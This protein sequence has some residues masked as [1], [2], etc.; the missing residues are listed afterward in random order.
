MYLRVLIDLA[1]AGT[2]TVSSTALAETSGVNA[3]KVRKDMSHLRI[4]G[5]RGVGYNIARLIHQIRNQLG[6]T[7]RWP[8]L[9]AGVGNLGHALAN[10]KGFEERGFEVV[11]LV[12]ADPGKVGEVVAGVEVADMAGL[13]ELVRSRGIAIGMICTP[14][15]P[16]QQVADRMVAAGV[17]SILN[18]APLVITVPEGVSVREVDLSTELQILAFHEQRKAPLTAVGV[19]AREGA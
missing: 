1:E 9:I 4:S 15:G 11:A 13:E 5:T 16:A 7:Q 18:F 12:D 19:A 17:R 2:L 10:Y 14:A 8:V 6:L 3:A